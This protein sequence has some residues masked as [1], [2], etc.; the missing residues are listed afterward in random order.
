MLMLLANEHESK[1]VQLHIQNITQ[2][3]KPRSTV[4]SYNN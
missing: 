4:F 1:N 3:D 2:Y